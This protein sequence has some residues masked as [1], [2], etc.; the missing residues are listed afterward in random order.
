MSGVV[1]PCLLTCLTLDVFKT[2]PLPQRGNLPEKEVSTGWRS[3]LTCVGGPHNALRNRKITCLH[4][5]G[6]HIDRYTYRNDQQYN[7][8]RY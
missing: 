4:L 2:P 3:P 7:S 6:V 5:F 8:I 1:R